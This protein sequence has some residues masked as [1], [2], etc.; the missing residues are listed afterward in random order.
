MNDLDPEK[1]TV[2]PET[3][4]Q[5]DAVV[6]PP[7]HP[8]RNLIIAVG[9]VVMSVSMIVYFS[10]Y[11]S[12][13]RVAMDNLS[14]FLTSYSRTCAIPKFVDKMPPA[15]RKVYL[16]ERKLQAVVDQQLRALD[17]GATCYSIDQ[18]LNAAQFPMPPHADTVEA[19]TITLEPRA[20][21]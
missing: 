12:H 18:A 8:V 10:Y 4:S 2:E 20:T 7:R 19:P 14:R 1:K 3:K 13:D 9:V 11:R 16:N 6:G 15:L 17:A 21:K 5:A